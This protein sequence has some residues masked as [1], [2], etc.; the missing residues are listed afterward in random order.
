MIGDYRVPKFY[1]DS[2]D[3]LKIALF[4]RYYIIIARFSEL[5]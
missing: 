3:G 1:A 5:R 4:T 2:G